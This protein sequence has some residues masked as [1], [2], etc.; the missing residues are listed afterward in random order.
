MKKEAHH[1]ESSAFEKIMGLGMGSGVP[2]KARLTD[3]R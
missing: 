2:E 1:P 3:R